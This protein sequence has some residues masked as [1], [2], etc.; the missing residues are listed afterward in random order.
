MIIVSAEGQLKA[1]D[2]II[3]IGKST[4]DDQ[5]TTVKEVIKVNGNEEIIIN[6][7]QNKYFIT[8]MLISGQ[9]WAKQVQ[10]IS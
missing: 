3:I 10:V 6:K 5:K 2:K 4:S 1:G 9:S 8:N 7:K